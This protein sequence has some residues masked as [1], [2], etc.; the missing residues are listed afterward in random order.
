[1]RRDRAPRRLTV[2]G[3]VWLWLIRH[4]HPDCRTVLSL[5]RAEHRHAQLRLVFRDGPGR[6]VAGYPFGRGDVAS[7]EGDVL[8]L[9]EPGVVRRFL[10]EAA[11]RGL[12]PTAHGVREEDAWPLYDAL[13]APT[14]TAPAED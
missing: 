10:E 9:N 1:M 2:D 11:A 8:N 5:R 7:A 4:V 13:A 14:P 3:T 6:I 12:L